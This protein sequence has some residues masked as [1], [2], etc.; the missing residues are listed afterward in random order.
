MDG[1]I[2]NRCFHFENVEFIFL[3]IILISWMVYEARR[4]E[5]KIS[6]NFISE[7]ITLQ[8]L[9]GSLNVFFYI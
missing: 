9:S 7:I 6:F 1:K 3:P 8:V 2:L 4:R 5:K